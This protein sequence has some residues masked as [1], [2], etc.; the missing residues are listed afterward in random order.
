MSKPR[1]AEVLMEHL[2][3]VVELMQKFGEG[4]YTLKEDGTVS[5]DGP[6]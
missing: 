1:A 6:V 5:F 4:V 3:R 2:A